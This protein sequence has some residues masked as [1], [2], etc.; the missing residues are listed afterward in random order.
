MSRRFSTALLIG[1]SSGIGAEIL[2]LLAKDGVRTA[3]VAR[4]QSE[5][6][7]LAA[8]LGRDKVL[9][10]AHDVRQ[11][12]SAPALFDQILADLGSIDLFIYN[13][14]VMPRVEESEY[15]FEKDRAMIEVNFLGAVAW[16]DLVGAYMESRRQGTIVG[17]SSVAGDRGRRGSPVY[18]AS[19]AGLTAYLEAMRNRLT[20]YGVDVVTVKPGPVQTPMTEGLKLPLMIPA[21][22]AAAG[23]LALAQK[24]GPT[25]GYVPSIWGPIM[26]IIRNIP[27]A[28]FR[29]TN[30]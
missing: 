21:A 3:A 4:R 8:V 18:T 15:N 24:G 7:G 5:L 6:E 19:K 20:R 30:I 25:E 23:T 9:P 28:I 27:S 12:D 10:Y 26:L 1:A 29:R 22:E 17:I 16:I 2:K 11:F 14:G 13:A